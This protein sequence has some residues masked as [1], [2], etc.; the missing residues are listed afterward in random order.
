MD[1]IKNIKNRKSW[2]TYKTE[3]LDSELIDK[4]KAELTGNIEGPLGNPVHVYFFERETTEKEKL[5]TY[6]MIKNAKYF[7]GGEIK[8]KKEAFLDFGFILEKAVL[9]LTDMGLGTCWLGGTFTKSNFM[10]AAEVDDNKIMPA[11]IA[12]GLPKSKRALRDKLISFNAGSQ[13]RKSRDKLF[14]NKNSE[15]ALNSKEAGAYSEVLEMVRLAP[16]A[17][18][19][20]PWRI[21]KD[22]QD[23]HFFLKRKI[24]Y[25]RILKNVDLQMI[26]MGIA[27]YHFSAAAN[28]LN[29]SGEWHLDE[30][31]INEDWEYVI[32]WKS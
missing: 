4:I 1:I 13:K 21:I 29:L 18:N 17:S 5:G 12:T 23:F 11:V 24:L 30:Y 19:L 14:F 20:Q 26:D 25:K 2:R 32:S 16:S 31:R 3:R 27:M 28:Q 10:E 8:P 22:E 7:I 15:T 9:K 6:G